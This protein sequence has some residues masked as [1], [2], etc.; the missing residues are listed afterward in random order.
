M[1]A[2]WLRAMSYL[3]DILNVVPVSAL[4]GGVYLLIRILWLK[5]TGRSRKNLANE[6]IRLLLVCWLAAVLALVWV[7]GN[8]WG[9]LRAKLGGGY[10]YPLEVQWFSGEFALTPSFRNLWQTAANGLLYLPF[11]MLFPLVWRSGWQ[12]PAVGLL[13]SLLMELVQPIV[14]RSFDTA[15]LI[16]NMLGTLIGWLLFLLLRLAAPRW[17]VRCQRG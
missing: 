2:I 17:V 9:V 6:S 13:L 4:A 16:V 15:D 7:P 1:N 10:P 14:G 3:E 11:G 8:F 5:K 12:V